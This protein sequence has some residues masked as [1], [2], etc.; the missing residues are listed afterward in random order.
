MAISLV[1][2]PSAQVQSNGLGNQT[3]TPV[4][5]ST[6]AGDL[7]L[8]IVHDSSTSIS[9]SNV[10]SPGYAV[11]AT[12]TNLADITARAYRL[13]LLWKIATGSD[14]NPAI[15]SN[16]Y[17]GAASVTVAAEIIVY[18]GVDTANPFDGAVLSGPSSSAATFTS[19]P[20]TL[21]NDNSLV[22]SIV[23]SGDDN[24]LALLAG[25]EQGF[26]ER[27]SGANYDDAVGNNFS[28]G[29]ADLLSTSSGGVTMPTWNQ[30][31]NGND[32]WMYISTALRELNTNKIYINKLRPAI[33][34]PGIAR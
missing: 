9:G 25:S 19:N 30:T 18:R 17:S 6:A 3:V 10:S 2:S 23:Q 34:R 29:L 32:G 15:S 5:P 11:K 27:I 1:G 20:V 16:G 8:L 31:V 22:L 12:A 21:L 4:M 26:T 24:A 28:H 14:A 7:I 13:S 33:F